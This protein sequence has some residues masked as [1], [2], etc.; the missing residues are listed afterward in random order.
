MAERHRFLR[1]VVTADVPSQY[2]LESG[3]LVLLTLRDF[4]SKVKSG[5][6]TLCQVSRAVASRTEAASRSACLPHM[7]KTEHTF[8]NVRY[9]AMRC[10]VDQRAFSSDADGGENIVA[11]THDLAYP[12]LFE[13]FD[14]L[15]CRGLQL[16]LEDY[17]AYQLE[18]TL[19]CPTFHPLQ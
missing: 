6:S 12:R 15:G 1:E 5:L 8:D 3:P 13:F 11:G 9:E 4:S 17:K 14:S 18:I 2:S 16:V 19:G 10:A 7:A